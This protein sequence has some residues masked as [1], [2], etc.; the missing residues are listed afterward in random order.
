M[1]REYMDPRALDGRVE[2]K[3]EATGVKM[4]PAIGDEDEYREYGD[5]DGIG[6]KQAELCLMFRN[7]LS[8]AASITCSATSSMVH[9]SDFCTRFAN[10]A[11]PRFGFTGRE[12]Q[13]G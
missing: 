4:G 1:N 5:I 8:R 10:S 13:S 7:S 2:G 12:R 3:D 6:E 9:S 11:L